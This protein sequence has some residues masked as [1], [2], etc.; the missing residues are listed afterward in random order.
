[1][2]KVADLRSAYRSLLEQGIRF[3]A[4]LLNASLEKFGLA[5]L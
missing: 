5:K 4:K 3:D 2:G 1:M